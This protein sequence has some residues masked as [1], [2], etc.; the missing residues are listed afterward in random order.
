MYM[1]RVHGGVRNP[2]TA[3]YTGRVHAVYTAVYGPFA[4]QQL[5]TTEQQVDCHR[6]QK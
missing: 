3:V 2:Y 4:K 6:R 1:S 5:N